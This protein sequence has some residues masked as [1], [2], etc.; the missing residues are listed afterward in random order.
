MNR[1]RGLIAVPDLGGIEY[2]D[3]PTVMLAEDQTQVR[4]GIRY[5][6]EHDGFSVVAEA[7]TAAQAVAAALRYEP[8]VC[9]LDVDVPGGAIDAADRIN[10]RLPDTK[11]AILSGSGQQA[12]VCAA[13]RAGADGY[14]LKGTPPDRLGV[15]LNALL[16]GE[17]AVPRALTGHLVTEVRRYGRRR[18]RRGIGARFLYLP[19]LLRHV[20]RRLR[21]G[22]GLVR[23]WESA[24]SRMAD[25]G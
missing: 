22:M 24:R 6:L 11:I 9:L 21:S 1:I 23:A 18:R 15:A 14:L 25:Y 2:A 17:A 16:H 5:A 10:S 12:D 19:R 7:A 8:Q 13:I 3:G 20:F 4:V